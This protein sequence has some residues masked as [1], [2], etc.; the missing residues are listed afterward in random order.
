MAPEYSNKAYTV[1]SGVTNQIW[2]LLICFASSY[3]GLENDLH[4]CKNSELKWKQFFFEGGRG[5][6]GS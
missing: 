5:G 3:N 6:G 1:S 4:V 2:P